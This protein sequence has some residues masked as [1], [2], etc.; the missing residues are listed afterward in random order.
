MDVTATILHATRPMPVTMPPE[1]TSSLPAA[2]GSGGG[3]GVDKAV[4]M[5]A[6]QC[7]HREGQ[8]GPHDKRGGCRRPS[9]V[10]EGD[11]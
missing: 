7:H 2:V 5:A 8:L 10:I 4:A 6:A 1:G 3:S 9:P 11:D